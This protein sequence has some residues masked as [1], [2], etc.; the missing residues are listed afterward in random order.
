[1]RINFQKKKPYAI[2]PTKGSEKAAGVD[3]YAVWDD[4]EAIPSVTIQPHESVKFDSGIAAE[5][6][7]GYVGLVF[8]RS[9]LGTKKQLAPPNCVG[10][11]D[12]DYRGSIGVA[13]QN[14]G[15]KS[16][17]IA[18]GER[19]AQL[20]IVPCLNIEVNEVEELSE[21]ERGEGGFGST[22]RM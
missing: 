4:A 12:S 21:T 10:V 14:S 2:L 3:L 20:V 6:P 15:T 1:M 5:I 13:L 18:Y 8:A 7:D 17:Y 11:I 22:G 16:Q 19:V 9:G